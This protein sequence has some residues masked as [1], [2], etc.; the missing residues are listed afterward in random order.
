[1]TAPV[2]GPFSQTIS[3]TPALFKQKLIG[4]K[5]VKPYDLNLQYHG[6]T[7][8]RT[9]GTASMAL[10]F[11]SRGATP[12][13]L[14]DLR[15]ASGDPYAGAWP[16]WR[17]LAQNAAVASFNKK[18]GEKAA[19]AVA[20][21]EA[22][23]GL[24]MITKRV[25]QLAKAANA[26]R[27]GRFY[28]VA[29][30]LGLT[31][32]T[33]PPK[34]RVLKSKRLRWLKNGKTGLWYPRPKETR[35]SRREVTD[36]VASHWIEYS[37]GWSPL[38]GDIIT[39]L[40]VLDEPLTYSHRTKSTGKYANAWEYPNVVEDS[41]RKTTYLGKH[42][43][44]FSCRIAA[45]LTVNN[46]NRNLAQRLG[47]TNLLSAGIELIPFSFVANWFVNLDE[48]VAQFDQFYGVTVN[49]AYYTNLLEST[50]LY[51]TTDL[52]KGT[53]KTT[54]VINGQSVGTSVERTIGSLPSVTFGVRAAYRHSLGRALN[55]SALLVLLFAPKGKR[56]VF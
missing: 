24:S 23:E 36:Y 20:M 42:T 33:R 17:N 27:K 29:T 15:D 55:Q 39:A 45:V 32:P 48:Y 13:V 46:P 51:T 2:T 38:V 34:A 5:Q 14:Q 11:A 53:G 37:F 30:T 50:A 19:L 47:L 18:R 16:I 44:K 1:M 54:V 8:K 4:Y 56:S 12:L 52:V 49:S 7:K 41:I 43:V 25:T 9:S 35:S 26:L 31:S 21:A 6:H 40:K 22:R 3:N 10:A 28:D